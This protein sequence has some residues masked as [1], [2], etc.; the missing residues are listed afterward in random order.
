MSM[1]EPKNNHHG[2]GPEV[3]NKP[4]WRVNERPNQEEGSVIVTEYITHAEYM[5]LRQ[6]GPALRVLPRWAC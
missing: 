3:L 1:R 6:D 2:F 4:S 5:L